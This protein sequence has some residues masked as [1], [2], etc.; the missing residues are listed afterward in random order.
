MK[1]VQPV[2][3][4]FRKF[5]N[6][7]TANV[8]ASRNALGNEIDRVAGIHGIT[9]LI[10][11]GVFYGLFALVDNYVEEYGGRLKFPRGMPQRYIC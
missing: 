3:D 5:S 10:V 9:M 7:S 8:Y 4:I 2:V 6:I 1:A 11:R